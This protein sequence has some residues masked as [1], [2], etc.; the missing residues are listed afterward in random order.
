M[1][2]I[3]NLVRHYTFDI[4]ENGKRSLYNA[5][6]SSFSDI[7][8]E[9]FK[10]KFTSFLKGKLNDPKS[11]LSKLLESSAVKMLGDMMPEGTLAVPGVNKLMEDVT[12]GSVTNKYVEEIFGFG[13]SYV[14]D[15][16]GKAAAETLFVKVAVKIPDS[17]RT[18][19]WYVV[20]NPIK[21]ADK[22]LDYIF[23][24]LYEAFPFP[25]AELGRTP[26]LR[27]P[28]YMDPK[29]NQRIG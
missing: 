3:F 14:T 24:S 5:V 29:T 1:V 23:T 9:F 27:D 28:L 25:T 4:D 16:L 22:L 13:A 10:A 12:I 21:A 17:E 6:I 8:L 2:Y 11:G 15:E 18:V 20:I 26:E 19:D 7:S